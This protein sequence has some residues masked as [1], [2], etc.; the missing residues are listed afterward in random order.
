MQSKQSKHRKVR[1]GWLLASVSSLALFPALGVSPSAHAAKNLTIGE[2][3]CEG[4]VFIAVGSCSGCTGSI[5]G[6][7]QPGIC[8][9]EGCDY[10]FNV[11][12][13]C[14]HAGIGAGGGN[15]L[16]GDRWEKRY[17]CPTTTESWMGVAF[18]CLEC[19]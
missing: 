3:P 18:N 11:V 2:T 17:P 13:N 19:L 5:Y 1:Y 9:G 12:I 7:I 6:E 16:C 8:D 14:G 10:L 15:I 4:T